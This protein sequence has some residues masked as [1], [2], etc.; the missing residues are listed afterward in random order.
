MAPT[1]T[2]ISSKG[3]GE[4]GS[5]DP[6]H[7]RFLAPCL[8]AYSPH[9]EGLM[10]DHAAPHPLMG[11]EAPRTTGI[12]AYWLGG[13]RRGGGGEGAEFHLRGGGAC[14][15]GVVGWVP[16]PLAPPPPTGPEVM[17]GNFWASPEIQLPQSH[18]APSRV[19]Q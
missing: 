7:V 9:P 5:D 2:R 11:S 16:P 18:E 3:S 13:K 1:Q 15:R 8:R 17:E 4:R 10:G 14:L 6:L 19:A 12:T